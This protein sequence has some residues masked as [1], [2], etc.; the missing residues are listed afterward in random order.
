MPLPKDENGNPKEI[1][2]CIA[3]IKTE[4]F[5]DHRSHTIILKRQY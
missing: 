5:Q 2:A 4:V 1:L 3:G